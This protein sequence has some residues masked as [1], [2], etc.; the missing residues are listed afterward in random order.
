MIDLHIHTHRCRHATGDL[1]EYLDAAIDAGVR[2]LA[3]TDHLPLLEDSG[4]DYAMCSHELPE[5]IADV[6]ELADAAA[7][8]GCE[9][10]VG[11][12]ADWYRDRRDE[13]AELLAPHRLDLVLGSVHFIDGWAFDDPRLRE[14]YS[15]WTPDDLWARYFEEIEAAAMSGLYDVMAHPDLIKK[16]DYRPDSDPTPW[17]ESAARA[18]AEAG[19]AIEVN[20]AGLRKAVEEIYPSTGFVEACFRAG[21]PAT[22]GSDAHAPRE[23]ASGLDAGL[24]LLREAGYRSVAVFR[25]RQMEEVAI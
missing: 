5:Y 14:Q 17:Y 19:V 1:S 21:V 25:D 22:I 9:V 13:V 10:L 3:F 11:V 4:H 7:A 16:F 8:R 24:E 15:L 20:T 12:E 18:F 6:R 2:I 23:V